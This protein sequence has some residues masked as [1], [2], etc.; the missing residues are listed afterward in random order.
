MIFF[1]IYTTLFQHNFPLCQVKF[2]DGYFAW[3]QRK[4]RRNFL[5]D[6]I[7]KSNY[8]RYNSL[9]KNIYE[10]QGYYYAWVPFLCTKFVI[11]A[12]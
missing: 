11:K 5:D 9:E 6:L 7:Q 10:L 12:K 8:R 1:C 3:L 2:V 4:N